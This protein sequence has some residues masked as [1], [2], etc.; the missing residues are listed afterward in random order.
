LHYLGFEP[1]SLV[2]SGD[3]IEL[4]LNEKLADPESAVHHVPPGVHIAKYRKTFGHTTM[5]LWLENDTYL[6]R[7]EKMG[8]TPKS[9]STAFWTWTLAEVPS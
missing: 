5:T 7:H 9:S 8:F 1:R 3:G 4:R 2:I 6:F